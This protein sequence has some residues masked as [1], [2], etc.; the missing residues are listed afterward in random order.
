MVISN[1]GPLIALAKSGPESARLD[2]ALRGLI[3]VTPSPSL[4]PEVK[5]VTAGLAA[6]LAEE[7]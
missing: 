3:K 6:R 7:S 5:I 2:K 4:A 1:T